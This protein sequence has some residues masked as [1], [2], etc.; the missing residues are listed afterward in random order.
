M[1][2]AHPPALKH[3]LPPNLA[4]VAPAKHVAAAAEFLDDALEDDA[5]E[6]ALHV[7]RVGGAKG[8]GFGHVEGGVE[9]PRGVGVNGVGAGSFGSVHGDEGG[10]AAADDDEGGVE[11]EGGG[12]EGGGEGADVFLAVLGEGMVLVGCACG[13]EGN[14]RRRRNA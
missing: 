6:R 4:I 13:R 12:R 5:P 8:E 14:V 1:T 10:A 11:G 7:F 2:P 3:K 9:G